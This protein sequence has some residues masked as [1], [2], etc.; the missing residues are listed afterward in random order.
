MQQF[1]GRCVRSA[2]VVL[3]LVVIRPD[4][5]QAKD[6]RLVEKALDGRVYTVTAHLDT[7]GELQ[8][9]AGG[10]KAKSL[11]LNVDARFKYGE[12]RLEGTGRDSQALRSVRLYEVARADILVDDKPSSPRLREG[13]GLIVAQGQADGLQVFSPSGPLTYDELEL[14]RAPGDPLPALAL[15]PEQAVEPGETWKPADWVLP[16]IS[17]LEAVEKSAL[18]CKLESVQGDIARI[19][20]AG[21]AN[22]AALGAA[23]AVKIS[24]HLLFDVA[25]AYV[26][27]L[28]LTQAEKRSVGVVSPGLN[29]L[30]KMVVDR[31]PRAPTTPGSGDASDRLSD[32]DLEKIP[33]EPNP[34]S[35]L[36]LFEVPEWKIRFYHDRQWHL[37]HQTPAVAVLR[38][39]S[40]GNLVA[41]C[42]INPLGSVAP[43]THTT[44]PQFQAAVQQALGKN[45]ERIIQAEKLNV[46]DKRFVYRVSA[47]GS[48][49]EIPMQWNYYLVANPD[50]RQLVLVFVVEPKLVEALG[51]RDVGIVSGIDFLPQ[52]K[53]PTLA[54]PSA[55]K[56]PGG[57]QK[58][59]P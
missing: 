47:V 28:E 38:L 17:G 6:Y 54:T 16:L 27:H 52:G 21:E 43:G 30:A 55:D 50:G 39:V 24:G 34:A 59:S 14:L 7:A 29:V 8:A 32:R 45:F 26:S 12:R 19:S 35:L 25:G 18:E 37:F 31:T 48:A 1:T 56:S 5:A 23:S 36:L 3:A 13:L 4:P 10:G 53:G 22:G 42:N 2:L 11:K 58:K 51:G 40:S 57:S 9:D 49:L 46:E 33:L 41:Q 20:F 44:E 15:L